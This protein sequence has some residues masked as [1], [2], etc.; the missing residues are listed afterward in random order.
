MPPCPAWRCPPGVVPRAQNKSESHTEYKVH[1]DIAF[2]RTLVNRAL[3]TQ[4]FRTTSFAYDGNPL[5]AY[6]RSKNRFHGGRA[7]IW[8]NAADI[9]LG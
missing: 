6:H 9:R 7:D 1:E 2:V 4:I 3:F 8:E 5:I